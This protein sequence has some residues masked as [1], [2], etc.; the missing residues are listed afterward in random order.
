MANEIENVLHAALRV[1][2]T[3]NA[4]VVESGAGVVDADVDWISDGDYLVTL[5]AGIGAGEVVCSASVEEGP[6]VI[7]PATVARVVNVDRLS[8]TTFRVTTFDDSAELADSVWSLQLFR[9]RTGA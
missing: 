1:N 5:R 6:A 3:N 8:D 4:A 2:G 7:P 9:L